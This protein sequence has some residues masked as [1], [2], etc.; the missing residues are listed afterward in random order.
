ME[1]FRVVWMWHVAE[2]EWMLEPEN[3]LCVDPAEI[4]TQFLYLFFLFLETIF[5]NEASRCCIH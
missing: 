4:H 5:A 3:I 2:Q 1:Q